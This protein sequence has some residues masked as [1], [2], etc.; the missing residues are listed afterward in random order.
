MR[1]A[2]VQS[3]MGKSRI[4]VVEW[5][6]CKKVSSQTKDCLIVDRIGKHQNE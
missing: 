6:D 1:R 3:D 5:E 4:Q 2:M